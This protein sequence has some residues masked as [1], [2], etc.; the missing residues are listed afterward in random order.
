MKHMNKIK[1]IALFFAMLISTLAFLCLVGMEAHAQKRFSTEFVLQPGTSFVTGEWKNIS[2]YI[3]T[4]PF[5]R[6]F[7]PALETG[8]IVFF[9]LK[10]KTGSKV[11]YDEM[12]ETNTY[13]SEKLLFSLG[14]LYS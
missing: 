2:P 7:T 1:L 3:Y 5:K 9:N 11:V 4:T 6:K 13:L 12:Y 14:L 10:G 8:V